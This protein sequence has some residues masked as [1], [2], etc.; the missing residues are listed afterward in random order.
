MLSFPLDLPEQ[1]LFGLEYGEN[2]HVSGQIDCT[3]TQKAIEQINKRDIVD[4]SKL[5]N[6]KPATGSGVDVRQSYIDATLAVLSSSTCTNW[7]S[8]HDYWHWRRRGWDETIALRPYL[9]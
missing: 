3:G 5:H 2:R 4:T 6:L 9:R 8:G 7:E 1:S